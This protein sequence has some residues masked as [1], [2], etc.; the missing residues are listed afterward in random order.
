MLWCCQVVL[1]D[2]RDS[3]SVC[4]LFKAAPSRGF[5]SCAAVSKL[6]AYFFPPTTCPECMETISAKATRCKFCCIPIEPP[7]KMRYVSRHLLCARLLVSCIATHLLAR[8]AEFFSAF[9]R[10][11]QCWQYIMAC[12]SVSPLMLVVYNTYCIASSKMQT[13]NAQ[14]FLYTS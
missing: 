8:P 1:F 14:V 2:M 5:L 4:Q 7:I 12:V 11:K 6:S 13:R 10:Q 3:P 9:V